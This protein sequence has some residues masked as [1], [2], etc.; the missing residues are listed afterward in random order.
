MNPIIFYSVKVHSCAMLSDRGS[1]IDSDM[2][3]TERYV[4][5]KN[6]KRD[7]P[8]QK[9]YLEEWVK[10]PEYYMMRAKC[11][12]KRWA[13]L[14]EAIELTE[15]GQA[16]W[17]YKIKKQT[18][19]RCEPG[20]PR[21]DAI[22]HVWTPVDVGRVPRID[23]IT[24]SDIERAY[25]SDT[26]AVQ[27]ESISYIEEVHLLQMEE[28]AKLIVPFKPDPF[29]GRCLFPFGADQRTPGGHPERT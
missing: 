17:A 20:Y 21:A 4:C 18:V 26:G 27:D 28:R 25:T 22:G 2:R 16:K 3:P 23:L 10:V 1:F 29:S 13:T 12:C 15:S 14:H 5:V 9:P 8:V 19:Y 11:V 7:E 6:P 24:R